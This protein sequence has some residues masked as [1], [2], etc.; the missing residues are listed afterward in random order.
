VAVMKRICSKCWLP[1]SE[2]RESSLIAR[3]IETCCVE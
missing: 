2:I 3:L 1:R